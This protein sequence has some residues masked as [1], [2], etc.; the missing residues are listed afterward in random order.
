MA[1]FSLALSDGTKITYGWDAALKFFL[2]AVRHRRRLLDYDA[3]ISGYDGLRGL[4]KAL[5]ASEVYSQDQLETGLDALLRVCCVEE[6]EDQHVREVAL[7]V[8]NLKK[9]VAD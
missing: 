8:T 4:L 5:V 6:I 2:V 7:I 1:R 9:A 3:T